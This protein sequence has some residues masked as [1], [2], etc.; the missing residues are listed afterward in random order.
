MKFIRRKDVERLT[1]LSCSTIY[2]YM[3]TGDFPRN[4]KIGRKAVAWNIKD[5]ENWMNEKTS[6]A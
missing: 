4:F 1:G 6:E 3:A 2:A 5:I